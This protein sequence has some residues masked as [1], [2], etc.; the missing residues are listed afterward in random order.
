MYIISG[1]LCAGLFS[2]GFALFSFL[3]EE[4]AYNNA[5]DSFNYL[6]LYVLL[7]DFVV[8][9][10]LKQSQSIQIVPYLTLPVKRKTLLNFLL[11]KELANIW[12]FYLLI[13]LIPFISKAVPPHYGYL[14]TFLYILFCYL[15]SLG[16]SLLVNIVK[17]LLKRSKWFLFLPV[18]FVAAI[19]GITFIPGVNV[20]DVIVRACRYILE[21][22]IAAWAIVLIV[23][24]TLWSVSL[25]TMNADIYRSMQGKQIS[26]TA[27]TFN[28]PFLVRLGKIGEF[29]NLE[30][31]MILRTKR[32]KMQL[33]SNLYLFVF[34]LFMINSPGFKESF[35]FRL[36]FTTFVI[37]SIGLILEQLIFTAES[38]FFDGLMARKSNLLDML[39]GK[40]IFYVSCSVLILIVL[41]VFAFM[42]N[43]DFLFLISDFFYTI[44][45]VFFVLFQNAVYNKRYFELWDSGWFNWKDSTSGNMTMVTV[46]YVF[47]LIAIVTIVKSIFN[48]TVSCYFMLIT[49]FVFTITVNYWL[50]WI[51][52]RFLKRRYENMEGFRVET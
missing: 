12:I 47:A 11:L 34:Y 32:L 28:V 14:N 26:N 50:K 33:F 38:S 35:F 27:M 17:N 46:L 5:I 16:N 44:G 24:G 36:F 6:L 41:S 8:K 30:L 25:S 21:N 43:I 19:V 39:K 51:Y 31:K 10:I 42:G 7:F 22:N 3:S 37:A 45:V 2:F 49:G 48:E 18:I 23:F 29:I 20:G 4:G 40:Y 15:L 52:N 1:L 13:L 9:Y